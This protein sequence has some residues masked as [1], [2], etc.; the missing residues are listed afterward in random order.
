MKPCVRRKCGSAGQVGQRRA[1]QPGQSGAGRRED[2]GRFRPDKTGVPVRGRGAVRR[3]A[4]HPERLLSAVRHLDQG[5]R[6]VSFVAAAASQ[7][8]QRRRFQGKPTCSRT[9]VNREHFP[10]F[11]FLN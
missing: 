4:R 6:G 2:F 7:T 10:K 1:Q 9:L 3:A 5:H 11:L 8:A